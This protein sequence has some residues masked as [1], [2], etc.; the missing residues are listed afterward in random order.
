MGER[1][2]DQLSARRVRKDSVS[3]VL[4]RVL[5]RTSRTDRAGAHEDIGRYVARTASLGADL[6]CVGSQ[7]CSDGGRKRFGLVAD[8]LHVVRGDVVGGNRAHQFLSDGYWV[9]RRWRS[10]CLQHV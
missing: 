6:G 4:C 10:D 3:G 8:V 7:R 9:V 2:P 5:G 1:W